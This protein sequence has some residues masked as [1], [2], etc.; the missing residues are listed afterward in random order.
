MKTLITK[1]IIPLHKAIKINATI[2]NLELKY[3]NKKLSNNDTT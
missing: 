3:T 1:K 2:K